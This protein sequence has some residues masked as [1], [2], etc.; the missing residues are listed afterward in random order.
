MIHL[1]LASIGDL[2]LQHMAST[3]GR[4]ESTMEPNPAHRNLRQPPNDW[5]VLISMKSDHLRAEE[6]VEKGT[7]NHGGPSEFVQAT[8]LAQ[9]MEKLSLGGDFTWTNN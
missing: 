4:Q 9:L 3:I 5:C 1:K 2:E 6:R 8:N 7:Y